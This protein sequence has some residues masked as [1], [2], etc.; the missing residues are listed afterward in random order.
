MKIN[1]CEEKIR[2][3]EYQSQRMMDSRKKDA[4]QIFCN[5]WTDQT[6]CGATLRDLQ[7]LK[8]EILSTIPQQTIKL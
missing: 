1:D 4:A 8:T 2:F 5:T 7:N 6:N 3:F